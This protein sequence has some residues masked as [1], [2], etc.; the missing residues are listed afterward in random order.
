V[1]EIAPDFT[2]LSTANEQVTLSSFKGERAVLI[3]F[4][5]LA[6]TSTC[7]SELCAFTDDFDSFAGTGVQILPISVD[8]APSLKEYKKKYDM[9]VELLSDFK[10][11]AS[12]AYGVL[13]D[14]TYYAQRS[15]FLVDRDGIVRWAHVETK[16]GMKRENAEILE[17]IRLLSAT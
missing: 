15:Y 10:R 17:Q 6:F 3:A 16:P 7:T 9:K 5:P 14:D 4:F 1:G 2:L 12:R 13:R 11:E 8:A